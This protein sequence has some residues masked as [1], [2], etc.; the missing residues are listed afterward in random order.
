M[1]PGKQE[2]IDKAVAGFQRRYEE[3]DGNIP[4]IPGDEFLRRLGVVK[5]G[6]QVTVRDA[7]GELHRAVADSEIE[8]RVM[9][10]RK[11]H[12]FPVVWVMLNEA[13]IP[14]PLEAVTVGWEDG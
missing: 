5:Q 12:D 6:D 13:R 14:W 7:A 11:V 10:G 1:K 2:R 9:D 4:T 3:H 8:P